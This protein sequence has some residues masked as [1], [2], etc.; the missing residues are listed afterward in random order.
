MT[1]KETLRKWVAQ[2]HEAEWRASWWVL[3]CLEAQVTLLPVPA[4]TYGENDVPVL[5]WS[6]PH[7]YVELEFISPSSIHWYAR[8]NETE[9][10]EAGEIAAEDAASEPHLHVWL[11]RLARQN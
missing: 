7:C 9:R 3:E 8:D 2:R 1:S 5:A 11:E 4:A 10:S 6:L